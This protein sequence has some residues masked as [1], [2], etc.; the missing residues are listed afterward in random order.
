MKRRE[1]GKEAEEGAEDV[2]AEKVVGGVV[3]VGE[4][5]DVVAAEDAAE[6]RIKML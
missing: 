1:D 2:G 6:E 5:V 3:G 4:E